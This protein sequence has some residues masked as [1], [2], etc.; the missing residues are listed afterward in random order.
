MLQWNGVGFELL[1]KKLGYGK[2]P[3]PKTSGN[4]ML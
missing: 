3:W 4:F 1:S 2:Y